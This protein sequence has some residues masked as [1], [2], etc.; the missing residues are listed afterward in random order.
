[1]ANTLVLISEKMQISSLYWDITRKKNEVQMKRTLIFMPHA[2]A[3]KRN[4]KFNK[5]H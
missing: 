2:K 1:M 3:F 5:A 4:W